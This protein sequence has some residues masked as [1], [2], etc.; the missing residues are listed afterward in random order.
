[1]KERI[2][3][4]T[5]RRILDQLIEYRKM[6]LITNVIPD[7]GI[8]MIT[9]MAPQ[10]DGY[11]DINRRNDPRRTFPRRNRPNQYR[12]V[13][14]AFGDDVDGEAD[15]WNCYGGSPDN[16]DFQGGHSQSQVYLGE[17]GGDYSLRGLEFDDI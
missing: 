7:G 2:S 16:M 6:R 8:R 13:N 17:N 4:E 5:P 10:I 12:G 9:R 14:C 1:M 15:N 11:Y 3:V